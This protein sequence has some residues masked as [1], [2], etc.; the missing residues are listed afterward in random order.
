[1][2]YNKVSKA[3]YAAGIIFIVVAAIIA[4][5][6]GWSRSDAWWILIPGV[7]LELAGMG[8]GNLG[9]KQ[10]KRRVAKELE[11]NSQSKKER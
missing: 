1:M 5:S 4:I 11:D 3:L 7:V 10:E 9:R 8:A 2:N 6:Q